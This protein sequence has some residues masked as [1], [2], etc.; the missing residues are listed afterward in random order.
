[1]NLAISSRGM[2]LFGAWDNR[3]KV[4]AKLGVFPHDDRAPLLLELYR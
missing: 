2:P 1:M 4:G 3:R